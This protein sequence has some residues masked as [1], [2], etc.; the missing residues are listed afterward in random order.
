MKST[1]DAAGGRGGGSIRIQ[2]STSATLNGTLKADG[3]AGYNDSGGGGSGGG[4]Y[5]A[6]KNLFGTSAALSVK[7]GNATG[8]NG[9]GGGGGRI[10]L[11]R[12][13]DGSNT[14]GWTISVSGGSGSTAGSAGTLF[15]GFT[16]ISGTIIV[17]R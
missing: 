16:S 8:G 15:M 10:A 2:A 6:C 1:G 3:Q 17:L 11:W 9:G 5:V 12:A 4:I 14:N 13:S 7:G